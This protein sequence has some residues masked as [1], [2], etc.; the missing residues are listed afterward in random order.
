ME[1]NQ[2]KFGIIGAMDI[3]IQHLC[4]LM[5][6]KSKTEISHLVF[7]EGE[8]NQKSCVVVQS[9][10]G[11]VN[12]ALCAQLLIIK[13]DVQTL[14]SQL[15]LLSRKFNDRNLGRDLCGWQVLKN[16]S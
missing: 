2:V 8:I 1:Q 7:Y 4:S 9:G 3:E 5:K 14:W 15:T 10:I 11:K 6:N 16:Q 12:A 13:F